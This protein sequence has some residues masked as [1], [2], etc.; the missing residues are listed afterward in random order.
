MRAR[1][2]AIRAST[3]RAVSAAASGSWRAR[4][5]ARPRLPG[6]YR[7]RTHPAAGTPPGPGR[8]RGGRFRWPPARGPGRAPRRRRGRLRTP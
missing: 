2:R 8:R 1:R 5:R 3:P 4:C 6:E 7:R